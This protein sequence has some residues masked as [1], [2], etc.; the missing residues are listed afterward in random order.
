MHNGMRKNV[1]RKVMRTYQDT[2][3]HRCKILFC[4]MGRSDQY[5]VIVS[6]LVL[7]TLGPSPINDIVLFVFFLLVIHKKRIR[8][9][10]SP[11]CWRIFF[12]IWILC[13]QTSLQALFF[14][15]SSRRNFKKHSSHR[16]CC[17]FCTVLAFNNSRLISTKDSRGKSTLKKNKKKE[18]NKEQM[19]R[20]L[21]F[22]TKMIF[23]SSFRECPWLLGL[24]LYHSANRTNWKPSNVRP[25][26]WNSP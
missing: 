4:C 8:F 1:H 18:M 16:S 17:C 2:W 22:R 20:F 19:E 15:E 12:V 5:Q 26:T 23:T 21:S 7:W 9:P 13:Q 11:D 14:L 24:A 25:I 10:R 6:S 3:N